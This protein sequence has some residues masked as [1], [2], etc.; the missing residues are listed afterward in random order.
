MRLLKNGIDFDTLPPDIQKLI[1]AIN[2]P[3]SEESDRQLLE[4]WNVLNCEE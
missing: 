4:W 3:E 1:L 2:S